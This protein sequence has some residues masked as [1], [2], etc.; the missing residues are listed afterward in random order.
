[1]KRHLYIEVEAEIDLIRDTWTLI[2]RRAF[3]LAAIAAAEA[4]IDR[5][6]DELN[7][8]YEE[9]IRKNEAVAM[10][11]TDDLRDMGLADYA[12]EGYSESRV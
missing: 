5:T 12:Y 6:V 2:D 9:E 10:Q 4:E 3:A 11:P 7:E 1:M 8:Q